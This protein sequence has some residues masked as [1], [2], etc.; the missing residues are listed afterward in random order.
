LHGYRVGLTGKL[1]DTTDAHEWHHRDVP[2]RSDLCDELS[3]SGVTPMILLLFSNSYG[4][5]VWSGP[6]ATRTI[7]IEDDPRVMVVV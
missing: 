7:L 3:S 1:V 4:V 6:V 5:F 2:G